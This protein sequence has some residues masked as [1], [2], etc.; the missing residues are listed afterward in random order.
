MDTRNYLI[1][2][3]V[4]RNYRLRPT[5][6][7]RAWNAHSGE[8]VG[9]LE[10]TTTMY[11]ATGRAQHD[12]SY[13]QN[14]SAYPGREPLTQG[15]LFLENRGE[16]DMLAVQSD[17]QGQ[18]IARALANVIGHRVGAA[19]PSGILTAD[20]AG[21]LGKMGIDHAE[22]S[23]LEHDDDDAQTAKIRRDMWG[24]AQLYDYGDA[25]YPESVRDESHLA[26]V[27][28]TALGGPPAL[29]LHM[30][31]QF[32]GSSTPREMPG[33][34]KL[35]EGGYPGSRFSPNWSYPQTT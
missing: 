30:S 32:I 31:S 35:F 29:P 12:G 9:R 19:K 33:Q 2:T 22:P 20:S 25:D 7:A 23:F 13:I 8:L 14:P 15:K 10:A 27:T 26:N 11:G 34:Q 1:D 28:P 5:I 24:D 3:E 17:H 4:D 18:G 21:M 16:A 6:R